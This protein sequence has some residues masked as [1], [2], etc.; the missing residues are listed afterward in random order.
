MPPLSTV[1]KVF[2]TFEISNIHDA[3]L[4]TRADVVKRDVGR[5][6]SMIPELRDIY[7]PCK[8]A[9]YLSEPITISRCLTILRHMLRTVNASLETTEQYMCGHKV[10]VYRINVDGGRGSIVHVSNVP[11]KMFDDGDG[12]TLEESTS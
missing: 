1:H 10:V 12:F 5:K 11:R 9:I 8:A 4:F 7:L 3:V 2:H 6:L